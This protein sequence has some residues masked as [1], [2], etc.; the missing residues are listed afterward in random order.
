MPHPAD[1]RRAA[2]R[3]T[4]RA[5]AATCRPSR[6]PLTGPR[7]VHPTPR[8]AHG[9]TIGARGPRALRSARRTLLDARGHRSEIAVAQRPAQPRR[10]IRRHHHD[11]AV[12]CSPARPRLYIQRH[13]GRAAVSSHTLVRVP[14]RTP[15]PPRHRTALRC[16]LTS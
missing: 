5:L 13:H 6:A 8:G 11:T 9:W 2:A 16:G 10:D 14:T 3:D 7:R 15:A 1:Q 4:G 12:A